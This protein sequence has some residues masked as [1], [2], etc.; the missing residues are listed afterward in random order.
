MSQIMM[1]GLQ[2]VD[3][4]VSWKI[5]FFKCNTWFAPVVGAEPNSYLLPLQNEL[6]ELIVTKSFNPVTYKEWWQSSLSPISPPRLSGPWSVIQT[7]IKSYSL[8]RRTSCMLLTW[9]YFVDELK[10][11]NPWVHNLKNNLKSILIISNSWSFQT[12]SVFKRW[13]WLC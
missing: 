9:L 5:F 1:I 8:H 7:Y 3:Q 12:G 13:L 2:R 6:S 11:M 10:M 4:V